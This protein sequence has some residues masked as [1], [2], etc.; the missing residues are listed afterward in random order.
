MQQ[1]AT[2]LTEIKD[3]RKNITDYERLLRYNTDGNQ[4]KHEGKIRDLNNKIEKLK[5]QIQELETSMGECEDIMRT[6]RAKAD[7][8]SAAWV[9]RATTLRQEAEKAGH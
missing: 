8:R 9:K 5:G 4:D 6:V 2:K 3:A 7:A 1:K